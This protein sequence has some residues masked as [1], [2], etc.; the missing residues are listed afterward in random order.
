M[1]KSLVQGR[2][3]HGCRSQPAVSRGIEEKTNEH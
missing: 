2:D 1:R 3:E